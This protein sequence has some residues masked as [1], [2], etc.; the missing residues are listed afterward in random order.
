MIT[1]ILKEHARWRRKRIGAFNL[2]ER[3]L[4]WRL[5]NSP[6][7]VAGK[8]LTARFQISNFELSDNGHTC[9]GKSKHEFTSSGS[10]ANKSNIPGKN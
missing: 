5:E 8:Q 7:E 10:L 1:Y 6:T 2:K 4:N 3:I 9:L